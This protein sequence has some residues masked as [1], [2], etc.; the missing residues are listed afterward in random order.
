MNMNHP[1]K[2]PQRP[3]SGQENIDEARERKKPKSE[4]TEEQVQKV[5][6]E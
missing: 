1:N 2:T 6:L 3:E 4:K 5:I